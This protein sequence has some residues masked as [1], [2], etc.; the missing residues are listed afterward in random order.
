MK[1]YQ[2]G[3]NTWF[4]LAVNPD[5]W[6]IGPLGVGKRNGKYF[7]YV[8]RNTQLAAYKDTISSLLEGVNLLPQGEY[9]LTF[10]FWRRLESSAT[11]RRRKHAADTTNLQK[12]TEDA[13]QG[14]LFDNDRD[15]RH[16]ESYLVSQTEDTMPMVVM[17][18]S[19]YAG[20]RPEIIPHSVWTEVESK[21]KQPEQDDNVWPPRA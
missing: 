15:V 14:V 1:R 17:R 18:A 21:M 20:F 11:D 7:P 6:A 9:S 2:E 16:V 3:N 10:F 12:A 19:L 4:V 5:P 8:G 13:L